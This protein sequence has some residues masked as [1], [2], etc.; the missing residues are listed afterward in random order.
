[1]YAHLV[2]GSCLAHLLRHTSTDEDSVIFLNS[3]SNESMRD[4]LISTIT[5]EM[6]ETVS[7]EVEHRNEPHWVDSAV[8][9]P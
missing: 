6:I 9:L 1:M 5:P 8:T 3:A 7:P 2:K 4:T